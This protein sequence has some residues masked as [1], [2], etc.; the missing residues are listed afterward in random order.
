MTSVF[1]EFSDIHNKI[2]DLSSNIIDLIYTSPP[3]GITNAQWDKPLNWELLFPE[4]WRVLKPNGIILL[5]ASMP[6]TYELLKYEKPKYHYIWVKNVA[7]GFLH[8]KKQP[9]RKTEE[10][11]VYYKKT[12]T[13]NPQ[14]KG[15]KLIKGCK[16]VEP[17]GENYFS[18][19]KGKQCEKKE[20]I[21]FYPNTLLEYKVRKN[22]NGISRSDE[23]IEYFIKTYSNEN[24]I[25]L[26]LTCCNKICSKIVNKLNRN[27]I[28]VDIRKINDS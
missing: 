8:A 13:Y 22:G 18:I 16:Y 23:L 5:H 1:Y 25:V 6:F 10:V 15:D 19:A 3:F 4:M 26:D 11:F 7:T 20:H 28:G 17:A 24:D 12:G 21:G 27:Y 9:L 2:K 14:M